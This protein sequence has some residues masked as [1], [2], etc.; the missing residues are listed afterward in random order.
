MEMVVI[1]FFWT[2]TA[3]RSE[4]LEPG[5]GGGTEGNPPFLKLLAD[6]E[7]KHSDSKGSPP[8]FFEIGV[9]ADIS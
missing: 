8:L 6:L 5:G 1:P 7:T 2:K 4:P 9:Y 3:W